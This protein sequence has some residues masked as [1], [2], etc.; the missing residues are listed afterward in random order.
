MTACKK[1][2]QCC[3]TYPCALHPDDVPR[4]AAFLGIS[5]K[6]TIARYLIWDFCADDTG[7][8][9]FYLCPKR[10]GDLGLVADYRWAM[11]RFRPC[12]FLS[13]DRLCRIHDVKPLGGRLSWHLTSHYTKRDAVR[14]WKDSPLLNKFFPKDHSFFEK[15]HRN[16]YVT[17][18]LDLFSL[19]SVLS[20]SGIGKVT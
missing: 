12:I 5:I 20:R 3:Y 9:V 11:E 4:I 10:K 16:L 6:K 15:L 18:L 7:R 2:G 17:T 8:D 1:C 14:E 13:K 19:I